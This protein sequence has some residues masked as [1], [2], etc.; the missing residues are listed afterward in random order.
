M[1]IMYDT[2]KYFMKELSILV[3][4]VSIMQH[5]MEILHNTEEQFVKVQNIHVGNV[6]I[7]QQ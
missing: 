7:Q 6:S 2:K 3:S 1:K 4:N 5:Q